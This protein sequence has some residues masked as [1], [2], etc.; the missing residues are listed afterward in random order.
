MPIALVSLKIT[1]VPLLIGAVTLAGRRWGPAVAGWLSG[2]PMVSGPIMYFIALD[3]GAAFVS[4][5]IVGML[6]GVFAMLGFILAYAW[7][8]TC[9]SWRAS[10]LCALTAYFVAVALLNTLELSTSVVT[11][12]VLAVLLLAPRLFPRAELRA[13][14]VASARGEIYVRMAAGAILV[15][16]VTYSAA[17][18]GAQLSGLF[19]MFPVISTV[20]A[21]FSHRQCGHEFTICLLRAM[22]FGW[23]AFLVFCIVLGWALPLFGIGAAFLAASAG[24]ACAQIVSGRLL[25]PRTR[26]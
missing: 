13:I 2:L 20:L 3:Q 24:A 7:V 16:A 10:L 8:S 21:V 26:S 11:V 14:D 5:A 6:L 17:S 18:F 15:L 22:V 1:L 12:M 19:S 23:Y 9:R 4:R 25:R